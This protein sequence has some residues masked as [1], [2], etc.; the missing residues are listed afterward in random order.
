MHSGI[1]GAAAQGAR[2]ALRLPAGIPDDH[3][4]PQHTTGASMMLPQFVPWSC[5]CE[6]I[7]PQLLLRCNTMTRPALAHFAIRNMQPHHGATRLAAQ[8]IQVRQ[9]L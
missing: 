5:P 9:A 2:C 6:L 7:L 4:S 8:P 1:R 3:P